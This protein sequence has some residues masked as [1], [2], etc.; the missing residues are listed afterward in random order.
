MFTQITDTG[1]DDGSCWLRH[2]DPATF[3]GPP[4]AVPT[5]SPTHHPTNSS[6]L[7]SR[8][9]AEATGAPF[10]A[11]SGVEANQ[12]RRLGNAA[13]TALSCS[14]ADL[15]NENTM[16]DCLNLDWQVERSVF[17]SPITDYRF[18]KV[19]QYVG[20]YGWTYFSQGHYLTDVEF[21]SGTH[22]AGVV[23]GSTDPG[24]LDDD[25]VVEV[26]GDTYS[27]CAQY[28]DDCGSLFCPTCDL[29]GSCD[30]TCGL[31]PDDTEDYSGIATG[32]KVRL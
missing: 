23:C 18:R 6:E 8:R 4:S 25:E 2:F 28:I 17:D 32:A 3:I 21:G 27:K 22:S 26:I 19:V 11:N 15:T 30:S 24:S 7:G 20:V 9:L 14:D 29:S 12:Q 16:Y 1:F 13:S 5:P 10:T 31:A